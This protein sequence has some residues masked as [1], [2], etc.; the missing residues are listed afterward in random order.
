MKKSLII[1]LA[2]ITLYSCGSGTNNNQNSGTQKADTV[3]TKTT[4]PQTEYT[5]KGALPELVFNNLEFTQIEY[6]NDIH[7]SDIVKNAKRIVIKGDQI[8]ISDGKTETVSKIDLESSSEE[9]NPDGYYWMF[10]VK[11]NQPLKNGFYIIAEYEEVC[12][13]RN[14]DPKKRPIS[15]YFTDGGQLYPKDFNSWDNLRRKITKDY[16]SDEKYN[17]ALEY[18]NREEPDLSDLEEEED[19]GDD[20]TPLPYTDAIKKYAAKLP[21]AFADTIYSFDE[22]ETPNGDNR[23]DKSYYYFPYKSGGFFVIVHV[24]SMDGG[25]SFNSDY[26]C[27]YIKGELTRA[28]MTPSPA[29]TDFVLDGNTADANKI[30]ELSDGYT[31]YFYDGLLRIDVNP[32]GL[33]EGDELDAIDK[34]RSA[35]YKWNGEKFVKFKE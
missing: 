8:T 4:A 26:E 15:I 1:A 14:E 17:E 32:A 2:A 7:V 35:T 12:T 20:N 25:S 24:C 18:I 23:T 34:Y 11:D 9:A 16:P 5:G 6:L 29:F 33:E 28:K 21:T 27:N 19:S 10:S 31:F 3:A 22:S 30:K 13:A